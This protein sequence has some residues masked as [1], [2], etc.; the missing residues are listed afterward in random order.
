V[1]KKYEVKHDCKTQTMKYTAHHLLPKNM[2]V[3][4]LKITITGK[5]RKE[6]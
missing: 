2:L 6:I 5:K 4:S 3:I 1:I